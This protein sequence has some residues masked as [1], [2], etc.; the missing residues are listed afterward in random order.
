MVVVEILEDEEYGSA[1]PI[2]GGALTQISPFLV[3]RA[4]PGRLSKIKFLPPGASDLVSVKGTLRC[5]GPTTWET[6]S[7]V[8]ECG[9]SSFYEAISHSF[10]SPPW[11]GEAW[12]MGGLSRCGCCSSVLELSQC[13]CSLRNELSTPQRKLELFRE[14]CI[15]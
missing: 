15:D 1:R 11:A 6:S 5:W 10:C 14:V 9:F 13:H 2:L 4:R 8:R 7:F 3:P 12:G